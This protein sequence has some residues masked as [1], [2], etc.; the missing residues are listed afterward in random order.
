MNAKTFVVPLDGSENSE[1]AL[2]VAEA[3]AT[4]VGG[5]LLLVS[6][7]LHGPMRPREYLGEQLARCR[8]GGLEPRVCRS[9]R[10]EREHRRDRDRAREERAHGERAREGGARS[11][12][13]GPSVLNR[14]TAVTLGSK[15]A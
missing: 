12:A 2:P 4:R 3:L 1:R 5:K 15:G 8:V 14:T 10:R 11:V 6:A 9:R 13:H 7:E